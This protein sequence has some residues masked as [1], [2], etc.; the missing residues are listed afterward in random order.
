[1]S[2]GGVTSPLNN[3]L[4]RTINPWY[5]D[6][7]N[8]IAGP[9]WPQYLKNAM[10]ITPPRTHTTPAGGLSG[11]T[12]IVIMPKNSGAI[13]LP[14][15]VMVGSPSASVASPSLRIGYAGNQCLEF[16]PGGSHI[17]YFAN[18][19]AAGT[20]LASACKYHVRSD[21]FYGFSATS[22]GQT[23]ADSDTAIF[24]PAAGIIGVYNPTTTTTAQT[25]EIYNTWSSTTSFENLRFKSNA[26]S[27]YQIGSAIG[28]AGG[29]NRAIDLGHW[30]AAGT[31]DSCLS[32][33]TNDRVGINIATPAYLSDSFQVSVASTATVFP[34]TG[35]AG[36][37]GITINNS[38]NTINRP[39]GLQFGGY[40][41][42]TFGGIYGTM[43]NSGGNTYGRISIALRSTV[44]G[45][46]NEVCRWGE[47]SSVTLTQWANTSGSPAAFTL[48]GAAHT[49]LTASTEA[50]D[51]NF[52]LARTVQFATGALTTQRAMRIQAPTYS[53]VGA[54]TITTASTLSISGPPVAGTNATITN[55]YALNVES[56]KTQFGGWTQVGGTDSWNTP[57]SVGNR[58]QM[59][60]SGYDCLIMN[61]GAGS[62]L[63]YHASWGV[64]G[65]QLQ[66]RSAGFGWSSLSN[67]FTNFDAALYSPSASVIEQRVG[68]NAQTFR[69]YNTYSSSTSYEAAV[70]DW[71]TEAN[72]LCIGTVKGSAGG[73]ARQLKIV[74]NGTAALTISSLQVITA[75]STFTSIGGLTSQGVISN[76]RY[77]VSPNI[78]LRRAG[79]TSDSPTQTLANLTVGSI[80]SYG[81]HDDNAFHTSSGASIQFFSTEN[82]T[83]TAQGTE[84]RFATSDATTTSP[85]TRLTIEDYGVCSFHKLIGQDAEITNTPSGTTQTITMDSG[86]HQ[87]LLLTSSTGNVT[88]TITVPS[89]TSSGTI[90][91]K[92]HATTPRNIT[93]TVS[94]GTI[95]WMGTQPTWSGD[96]TNSIRI[97]SWRRDSS[98]LYL[99]STESV[100]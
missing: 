43:T 8:V 10:V 99:W 74:T 97:V 20:K 63:D 100:I 4:R 48:T 6:N 31:F 94:S 25:F 9:A 59:W 14:S 58:V 73:S 69:V 87:T 27:A 61:F 65:L 5:D 30:N 50:T 32:I 47:D 22:S 67:N 96:A 34:S 37:Y 15:L 62:Q 35:A 83:T 84:I 38:T 12:P 46:Q 21:G 79:G 40:E 3:I 52:N 51:I 85:T 2:N 17:A 41:G 1:M 92:Q 11:G 24:R 26:S 49:T 45:A 54:S 91:V 56:G 71:Q 53:F 75:S 68:T 86:N 95:K 55:A 23:L 36:V 44:T 28:S 70:M 76:D 60:A 98:V 82:Y 77:G 39:V 19:T 7:P 16:S 64:N 66:N 88:V 90:I 42:W 78:R 18:G 33:T 89:K 29:S 72:T 93:W 13:I 80:G 57:L 81:Y